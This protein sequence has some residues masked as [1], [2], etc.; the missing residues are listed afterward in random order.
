MNIAKRREVE[1]VQELSGV[2]YV[3]REHNLGNAMMTE[4]VCNDEKVFTE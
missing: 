4:D 3:E 1:E 2:V